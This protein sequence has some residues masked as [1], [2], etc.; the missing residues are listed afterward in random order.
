MAHIT[1]S[2]GEGIREKRGNGQEERERSP[3]MLVNLEGGAFPCC[4][5]LMESKAPLGWPVIDFWGV[6]CNLVV[7]SGWKGYLFA[8]VLTCSLE[9]AMCKQLRTSADGYC[10]SHLHCLGQSFPDRQSGKNRTKTIKPVFFCLQAPVLFQRKVKVLFPGSPLEDAS[11]PPPPIQ[12]R[13]KELIRSGPIVSVQTKP[14][15]S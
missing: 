13:I 11:P 15:S 12:G 3:L 8:L 6:L 14:Q 5:T 7:P 4:V 10:T 1:A 9:P 2:T